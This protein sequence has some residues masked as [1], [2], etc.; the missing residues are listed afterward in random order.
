MAITNPLLVQKSRNVAHA[1]SCVVFTTS[2]RSLPDRAR[3]ASAFTG[4]ISVGFPAARAA[5]T[6]DAVVT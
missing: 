2:Q 1:A 5:A 3:R 4:R 6:P